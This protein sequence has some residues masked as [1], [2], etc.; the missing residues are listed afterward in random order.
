MIEGELAVRIAGE[1]RATIAA[2]GFAAVPPE[3]VHT[4]PPP[5]APVRFLNVF[6]PGG[7]E[8]F[9][10]EAARLGEPPDPAGYDIEFA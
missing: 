9:L 6:T 8:S 2:G 10:R 5:A 1:Q 7:M 3:T 4:S